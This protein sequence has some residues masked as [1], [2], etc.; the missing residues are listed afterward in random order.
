MIVT[1]RKDAGTYTVYLLGQENYT[2]ESK[3]AILT[4][5]KV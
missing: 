1:E 3:Q 4:I 2:N 5:D